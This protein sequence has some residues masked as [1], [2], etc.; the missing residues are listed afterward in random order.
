MKKDPLRIQTHVILGILILQYLLGMLV[1]LF[2]QFPDTKNENALWEFAKGQVPVVIHIFLAFML[3]AGSIVLLIRAIRRKDK[4]WVIAGSV[5][6]F[7]I[8]I[9]II[10][11]AQFVPTQQDVY[12]YIMASAFILA[13][14]SY[15]WGMY[16]AKK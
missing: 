3:L 8:L 5:G 13:F 10:A 1:N 16:K 12:S 7:W 2:V 15:G 11:G 9:A 6:F 4:N 14:V